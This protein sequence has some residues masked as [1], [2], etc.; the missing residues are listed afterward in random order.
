[1]RSARW[2]AGWLVASLTIS[3]LMAMGCGGEENPAAATPTSP[4]STSV[5][6]LPSLTPTS[7]PSPSPLA[8]PTPEATATPTQPPGTSTTYEV[9]A[10]DTL[11]SIARRFDTTVEAIVAANDLTDPSQ[12]EVGQV[13]VIPGTS[14]A[15][16]TPAVTSTPTAGFAQII[17]KGDTSSQTVYLTFDAGSDAGFTA[18]ILD[19]LKAN[20]IVA[21]FG[22]TGR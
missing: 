3:V 6:V 22:V 18:Q 8:S 1:M 20:G 14:A 17:R 13:L 16:S 10:G 19:T 7:T 15:T 9:Q 2:A 21:A 5:I 12:I 4:P 11:F